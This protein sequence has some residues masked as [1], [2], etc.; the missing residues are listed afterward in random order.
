MK[1]F[2]SK[3]LAEEHGLKSSS[4]GMNKEKCYMFAEHSNISTTEAFVSFEDYIINYISE[5]DKVNMYSQRIQRG[6]QING[7]KF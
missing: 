1:I 7:F 5:T 3:T 4:R 6:T 2:A